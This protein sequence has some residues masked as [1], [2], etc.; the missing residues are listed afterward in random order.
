[1]KSILDPTFVYVRSEHT[2]IRRTFERVRAEQDVASK[3]RIPAD[4]WYGP[5]GI[6]KT[7]IIGGVVSDD[8]GA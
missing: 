5:G 6:G 1:M 2:D 7:M 4:F 3:L 8:S